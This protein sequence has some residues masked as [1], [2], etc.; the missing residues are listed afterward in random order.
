MATDPICGMT[1][2]TDSPFHIKNGEE[3]Y[4]FC[5]QRCLEKYAAQEGLAFDAGAG[6]SCA[7]PVRRLPLN[8][9]I[10]V[11]LI[12]LSLCLLSYLFPFLVPFRKTLGMYVMTIWWA[13]LLGLVIGGVMDHYVP[14]EYFSHI[15]ARPQKRTIVYAVGLGFLMS[16]CNHGI[17]A[18][19]MQL[20]KKGASTPAVV[21]FLLASPWANLPL[22]LMMVGFFG[23][24]PA[25]YIIGSAIV[26]ALITGWVYQVLESRG[27][28]EVNKKTAPV[29]DDYSIWQ[30]VKR[31]WRGY[32]LSLAQVKTDL[33][34]IWRGGVAL[35]DMVLWWILIGIGLASLSGAYIPATIFREW[36]GPSLSGLFITL[37]VATIIEICSEGSAPLAFEIFRQT[38]ALGNSLAFLMAGVATDYTEIGLIWH[39]IGRRAAIWMP[40]VTVPQILLLGTIANKLFHG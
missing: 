20:H 4:Y 8:K 34:G 28:V 35:G 26:V 39:N 10:I 21:A 32:H 24:L 27:M 31:R 36:M 16:V 19:S 38:G 1:A 40:V 12:L 9:N 23:V 2:R 3:T 25:M 17:L 6:A 22:T 11:A 37:I 18:I 7:M 13:V 33:S 15:L 30:D 14:R 29:D 5:S